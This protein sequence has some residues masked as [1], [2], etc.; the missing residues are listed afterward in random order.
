MTLFAVVNNEIS[1]LSQFP[2][3]S[4]SLI[5]HKL[6][7]WNGSREPMRHAT[8]SRVAQTRGAP[9]QDLTR[10]RPRSASAR[11]RSNLARVAG[12]QPQESGVG[13]VTGD[14]TPTRE[15]AERGRTSV[16]FCTAVFCN[17]SVSMHGSKMQPKIAK[18]VQGQ[19]AHCK[20]YFSSGVKIA[21]TMQRVEALLT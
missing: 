9:K 2:K 20:T 1:R 5:V 6:H 13:V 11:V 10:R 17:S 15:G 21:L 3:N 8:S 19:F 7:R 4:I 16:L 14:F 18:A 12:W